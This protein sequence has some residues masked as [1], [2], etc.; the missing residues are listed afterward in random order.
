MNV[1]PGLMHIQITKNAIPMLYATIATAVMTALVRP[2][3][4]ATVLHAMMSTNA[5]S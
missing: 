4:S 3:I 1:F 5:T 2:G